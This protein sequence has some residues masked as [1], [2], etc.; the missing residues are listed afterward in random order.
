MSPDWE[1]WYGEFCW[2]PS[3]PVISLA[4]LLAAEF[5]LLYS[6]WIIKKC[7]DSQYDCEYGAA[8]LNCAVTFACFSRPSQCSP[9]L[10][11]CFLTWFTSRSMMLQSSR[12]KS[13]LEGAGGGILDGEYS[14]SRACPRLQSQYYS[15]ESV[16][17]SGCFHGEGKGR[18]GYFS[19]PS[20][21]SGRTQIGT[22]G[23]AVSPGISILSLAWLPLRET[24]QGHPWPQHTSS[25]TKPSSRDQHICSPRH[26]TC[27]HGQGPH[28]F[29]FSRSFKFPWLPSLTF[30]WLSGTAETT[31]AALRKGYGSSCWQM[32]NACSVT[33]RLSIPASS[34]PSRFLSLFPSHFLDDAQMT[35]Q[36]VQHMGLRL[37]CL[38]SVGEY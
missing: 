18:E 33:I 1:I 16:F 2:I 8:A 19:F 36:S 28:L 11:S 3:L 15:S 12:P 4:S 10:F 27:H 7:C 6:S 20:C 13:H 32:K 34:S 5:F 31:V 29:C 22:Q 25:Q 30:Q 37:L 17:R 26:L 9:C 14:K 35:N 21:T 38:W 23:W 24:C